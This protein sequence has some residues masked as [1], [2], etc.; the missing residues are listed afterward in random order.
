MISRKF[1]GWDRPLLDLATEQL[2][3][4]QGLLDAIL[5]FSNVMF[6][7]PTSQSGRKFRRNIS[8]YAAAENA[9]VFPGRI[10]TLSSLISSIEKEDGV[11]NSSLS[12][13][14]WVQVLKDANLAELSSLF[15]LEIENES[16]IRWRI[17]LA[18]FFLF[19]ENQ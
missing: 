15:P 7:L 8:R 11:V 13:I 10:K 4:D 16:D 3:L 18:D 19:L 9:V 14:L 1:L 6:F 5:D 17:G 2:A 12:F